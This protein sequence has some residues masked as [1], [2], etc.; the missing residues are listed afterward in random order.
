MKKIIAV[1]GYPGCGKSHYASSFVYKGYTLVDDPSVH[2]KDLQDLVKIFQ[3]NPLVVVT[4]PWFVC[5][6]SREGFLSLVRLAGLDPEQD[7]Q[8]VIFEDSPQKCL[9]N[10]MRRPERRTK[11]IGSIGALVRRYSVPEG[12]EVRP[13]W[14]PEVN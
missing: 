14:Q 9:N 12:A 4:D 10:I 8:W 3:A 2:L 7:V 1:A 5:A 6:E 11:P 13:V